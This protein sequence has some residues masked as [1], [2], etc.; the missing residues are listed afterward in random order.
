MS[1]W[2]DCLYW[3]VICEGFGE[4]PSQE[5]EEIQTLEGYQMIFVLQKENS[6]KIVRDFI[7]DIAPST[8]YDHSGIIRIDEYHLVE[9]KD[10]K[11]YYKFIKPK[12]AG[13]VK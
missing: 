5:Q 9:V 12:Q 11:A 8:F 4:I 1:D 3:Q 6:H 2:D 10:G 7:Y 13:D